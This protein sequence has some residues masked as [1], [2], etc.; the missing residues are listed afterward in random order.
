LD[1][2]KV[3]VDR[4]EAS[5]GQEE[6]V[7]EEIVDSLKGGYHPLIKFSTIDNPISS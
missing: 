3:E 6:K 5:L 2:A 1:K 7:L 4:L